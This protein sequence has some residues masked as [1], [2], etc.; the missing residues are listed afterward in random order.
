MAVLGVLGALAA[1]NA[2]HVGED[3]IRE[4]WLDAERAC[5][6]EAQIAESLLTPPEEFAI[7]ASLRLRPDPWQRD[8]GSR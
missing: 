6:G 4:I 2:G 3:S 1:A 5:R 7:Q 8:C